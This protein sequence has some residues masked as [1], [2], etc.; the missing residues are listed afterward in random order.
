MQKQDRAVAEFTAAI[1]DSV[2][3]LDSADAIYPEYYIM[4]PGEIMFVIPII[5]TPCMFSTVI[6]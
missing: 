5:F 3:D 2:K 4:I 6:N 1:D